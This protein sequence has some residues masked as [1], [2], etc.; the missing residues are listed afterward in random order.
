M[1]LDWKKCLETSHSHA[2]LRNTC[3]SRW[4]PAVSIYRERNC[5]ISRASVPDSEDRQTVGVQ[6]DFCCGRW[7]GTPDGCLWVRA[8][9][10]RRGGGC[11]AAWFRDDGGGQG[12]RWGRRTGRSWPKWH[13]PVG[14]N[15]RW[16]DWWARQEPTLR[17]HCH[18]DEVGSWCL[19]R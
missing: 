8:G 12:S 15:E 13:W 14:E 19:S 11:F 5:E 17:S 10:V 16:S 2:W 3:L 4:L 18:S 7:H 6:Q 9:A 1:N